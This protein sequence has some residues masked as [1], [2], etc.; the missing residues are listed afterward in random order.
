[1]KKMFLSVI[2]MA[3]FST[4][5][6]LSGQS[7][8]DFSKVSFGK[9]SGADVDK[10]IKVLPDFLKEV[11]NVNAKGA[12]AK[13]ANP[14]VCGELAA[15]IMAAA[16]TSNLNNEFLKAHGYSNITEFSGKLTPVMLAYSVIKME[17]A[18]QMLLAQTKNM[19]ANTPENVKTMMQ[20]QAQLVDKQ[21]VPMK[22]ALSPE[23][24]NSV[25]AKVPEIDKIFKTYLK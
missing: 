7:A 20:S 23:L 19:P 24:I 12:Q 21:L 4:G 14:A 25:K 10:V 11:K 5:L 8:P 15:R 16:A 9:V 2:M 1:M 3:V 13:G 6:S 22:K 18:K 17:E